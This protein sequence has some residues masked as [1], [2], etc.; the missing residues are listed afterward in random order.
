MSV[1]I[2]TYPAVS[3]PMVKTL[4]GNMNTGIQNSRVT[5][6]K[7]STPSQRASS[8][9]ALDSVSKPATKTTG[10][11][12]VT[13]GTPRTSAY[14]G[15]VRT[16]GLHGNLMKGISSKLSAAQSSQQGGT[17]SDLA[18]RVTSLEQEMLTKQD[19]LES[20][21]G[22]NIDGTVISLSDDM[23]TM[24]ERLEE[25]NQEIGD[26]NEQVGNIN[27]TENYYTIEETQDYVQ[28]IVDEIQNNEM[29]Y[30]S[31]AKE[32]K[33]VTIIDDFDEEDFI[34]KVN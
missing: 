19:I 22:I 17:T 18:Q 33:R 7:L 12:T 26:L 27:L 13:S 5:P 8:V 31:V 3:A 15:S 25:L 29:I 21:D 24:T 2:L 34:K 23:M 11:T 14:V 4:G 6:A 1:G 32:F 16:P 9:R 20:G 10:G 28:Q 30:D